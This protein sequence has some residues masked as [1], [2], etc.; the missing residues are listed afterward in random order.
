MPQ[1]LLVCGFLYHLLSGV[2]WHRCFECCF[3][4]CFFLQ[5]VV[6][7]EKVSTFAPD[8]YKITKKT[9]KKIYFSP[10]IHETVVG[11][12]VGFC[13]SPMSGNVVFYENTGFGEMD[14]EL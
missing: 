9:M 3:S 2:L 13:G 12:E 11:V 14:G 10:L 5:I 8:L 7:W 4:C 6:F 1:T